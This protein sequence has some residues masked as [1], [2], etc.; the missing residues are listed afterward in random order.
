[1]VALVGAGTAG[2]LV[3]SVAGATVQARYRDAAT[4]AWTERRPSP[5]AR[6]ARG[7]QGV[8][9]HAVNWIGTTAGAL[10]AVGSMSL[11]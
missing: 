2:M 11:L 8:D 7:W 3:D 9:N 4:G 5:D 1:M 6:P 10:L